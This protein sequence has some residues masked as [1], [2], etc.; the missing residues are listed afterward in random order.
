MSSKLK[1]LNQYKAAASSTAQS[2]SSPLSSRENISKLE[3]LFISKFT[4]KYKLTERDIQKAFKRFDKDGSGD[5][6][7]N[8][9]EK[10]IHLFLNGV[11][12]D[13]V[14][15][16]VSYYDV[17]G[18]GLISL[19]EFTQFLISRSSEN[20]NEWLTVDN[21]ITNNNKNDDNYIDNNNTDDDIVSEIS[22]LTFDDKNPNIVESKAKTFL[23]NL[24]GMLLKKGII[25]ILL[26]L[27]Y[28][29]HHYH[30]YYHY[31][32]HHRHYYYYYYYYDYYYY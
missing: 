8:E 14:R 21:L 15:Q 13:Q 5:L 4:E 27:S 7:V 16:L 11:S 19:S 17:D 1:R 29:H 9:L 18:D 20:K 12:L 30:Y 24:K 31:Y 26:L 6:D 32:Y 3:N 23:Q 28:Y 22:K 25:I 2:S 10:A